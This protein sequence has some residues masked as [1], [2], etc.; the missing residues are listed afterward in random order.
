MGWETDLRLFI[1]D[2]ANNLGGFSY[3]RG[4]FRMTTVPMDMEYQ[5]DLFTYRHSYFDDY[6][7]NNSSS[8]N[9]FRSSLGSINTST[10][11]LRSQLIS[12]LTLNGHS[13]LSIT[14]HQQEDLRAKRG[15]IYLDYRRILSQQHQVGIAHT[16]SQTKSD[17]DA[18]FYYRYGDIERGSITGE[19]TALDWA[20]NIVSDISS[21]RDSD[22]D[23]RQLYSRIPMLY[24]LRL[25]SPQIGIFRGEAVAAVQP[26]SRSEVSRVDRPD[27]NYLQNDWVNYQ[28]ALLEATYKNLTAGIIYQRTFARMERSPADGSTYEFDYGNRQI[29]QRGGIYFTWQWRGF[30]IEQ[31]FW[32]ERNRDE[33]FD[34]NPQAFAAQE[35]Q[36]DKFGA[37]PDRYPF[38]FKE[39]RRFNKTRL[40]YAP[41]NRLLSIYLEHNGDWRDLGM[42]GHPTIPARNYRNYYQNHI[43]ERTER[44]TLGIGF[45]FSKYAVM[46]VGASLDLDGDLLHGVGWERENASRSYFD[47]GFGQLQILW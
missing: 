11:A 15:L 44:L 24:T 18:T 19:V 45:N 13:S 22:Y 21:G 8:E 16:L 1:K 41:P 34:E 17:L 10:F 2:R 28:A 46:T 7:W 6:R 3:D 35:P 29:Q 4:L 43:L 30:G 5:I 38:D 25:Q 47:G 36:F 37:S 33:Q 23:I 20:N 39:I 42:D 9:G 32:I 27:Q 14:A 31:W 40:F 26:Q 12:E